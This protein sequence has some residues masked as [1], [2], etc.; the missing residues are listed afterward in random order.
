ML[1]EVILALL[2]HPGGII[3]EESTSSVKTSSGD[4][5]MS[6]PAPSA[7]TFRVP[8]S[9][10]FLTSTEREAINR[11]VGMGSTYRHLRD[12]VKPPP[13]GLTNGTVSTFGAQDSGSLYVRAFKLAVCEVLDEYAVR[14]AQVERDVM[15]D[16]TLTLARVYAGVRE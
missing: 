3:Q 1:H 8:K 10:T 14:V 2:G 11:V 9:I 15:E 12:F 13:F 7:C 4:V 5:P 16:P 6:A